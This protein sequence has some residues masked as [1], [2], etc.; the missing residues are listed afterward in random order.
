MIDTVSPRASCTVCEAFGRFTLAADSTIADV[1]IMKMISST[2]KMSVS[3]VMLISAMIPSDDSSALNLL[4]AMD[5]SQVRCLE[6]L[7]EPDA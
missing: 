5:A 6:D 1:V 2:R 3:G 4:S 7:A